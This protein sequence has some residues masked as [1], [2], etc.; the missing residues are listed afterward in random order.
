MTICIATSKSQPTTS[1]SDHA[2]LPAVN[3]NLEGCATPT[4]ARTI[5]AETSWSTPPE[6]CLVLCRNTA[7]LGCRAMAWGWKQAVFQ[8]DWCN[9]P[10]KCNWPNGHREYCSNTPGAKVDAAF[11]Q[12]L[13]SEAMTFQDIP[14]CVNLPCSSNKKPVRAICF[15]ATNQKMQIKKKQNFPSHFHAQYRFHHLFLV[16]VVP[17]TPKERLSLLFGSR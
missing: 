17:L 10:D 15:S 6:G 12:S 16:R 13:Y 4:K 11:R 7:L 9:L 2:C 1:L 8:P 3:V 5:S 14:L